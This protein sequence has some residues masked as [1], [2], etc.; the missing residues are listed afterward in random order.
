MAEQGAV[1]MIVLTRQQ[2]HVEA[3]NSA[4]RNA[5]HAA[6][7]SWIRE[8]ND[9]GDALTQIDA[10]MLVAFVGS[11]E[12]EIQTV[13]QIRDQLAADVPVLIARENVDEETIAVALRHGAR[14]V[15]SLSHRARLQYVVAR[16]LKAHRLDRRLKAT[17]AAAR[18]YREQ[19]KAF[20]SGS[21]DAMAIVQE[22]IIVEANPA[23]L[24]LLGVPDA[25]L[26]EGQPLMDIFEPDAQ[27]A[28][29]GG[30]VACLQGR[31]DGHKLRASALLGNGSALPLELGLEPVDHEG[32]PAVRVSVPSRKAEE[33][34]LNEQ[35]SDALERDASSG[36]M[37]R[38]FFLERLR[39]TLRQPLRGGVRQLVCL[40]PD[41]MASILQDIGQLGIED[42]IA[43]FAAVVREYLQP[44]DLVG[45][46]GDGKFLVF[47]ER[48]TPRDVELW[49]ENIVRRTAEHVFRA[50]D[51]SISVTCSAGIALLDP[52][53][54]E[55]AVPL[56]DALEALRRAA[57]GGGGTVYLFDHTQDDTRRIVADK[58]WV[59]QIKVALME[60]RFRLVQQPIASL[61]GEDR[62]I[63][64]VL[65]R[66]VDEQGEEVLPSEFMAAAE[67]NDLMKNIDRW[68][69]GASMSFCVS[70]PAKCLFV[71]LSRDS[72]RD[73]S[74]LPWLENQLRATRVEPSRIAFE[75]SE[76][77]AT[78]H[79]DETSDCARKL[80]Q[81]GF[82]FAIE[83]Y[84]A[85]RDSL[86]LLARMPLD[87]V[88]VDG[89]LMQGLATD[90][91][92]QESVRS[93]VDGAKQRRVA[94]IAERVEDA[95]TMA[96]L[97]QLGVEFIQGY[98]VNDPESVVIE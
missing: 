26:V 58:L 18:E 69:V 39:E 32:G 76:K 6:H 57:E 38:R 84:G 29:R 77:V 66:M 30:L 90:P 37:Q 36:F 67:R 80:R 94:T 79:L 8:L 24:E 96:V 15:V 22:G 10:E 50:A 48:G 40:E 41:K 7:C 33:R 54:T 11:T 35:L 92:A 14:D 74:L 98:F 93:L 28:I 97:W 4:L 78:Q 25:S 95:N 85:G 16:E 42:F 56:K 55:A 46:F 31:W 64:D 17:L 86:Q 65:V 34:N 61:M 83:H 68:V 9:L 47:L 72:V 43:Q 71:R 12:A 23:W 20:M 13:L 60:N 91:T 1:P 21:A 81:A 59:R 44:A 52:R 3:I 87:F 27:V 53:P 75:I 2:D 70:R 63:F 89:T 88:K 51:K 62:G 45:R 19:L 5:G 82:R 49:A 73:Q